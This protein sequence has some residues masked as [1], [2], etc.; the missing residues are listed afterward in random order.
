MLTK[1]TIALSLVLV[2]GAASNAVADYQYDASGAPINMHSVDA[3]QNI[4][5]ST[6]GAN[7]SVARAVPFSA[8]EKALFDRTSRSRH[9]GEEVR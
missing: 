2:M 5:A 4:Y 6:R 1:T 9:L 3:L 8:G 7:G